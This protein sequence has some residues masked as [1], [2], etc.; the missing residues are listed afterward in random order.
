[1]PK[2]VFDQSLPDFEYSDTNRFR[3]RLLG[4]P[5]QDV[6][7][8]GVMCIEFGILNDEA[9]RYYMQAMIAGSFE[10]GLP[11]LDPT[12]RYMTESW[13]VTRNEQY[14]RDLFT[15]SQL[16]A[17]SAYI[18]FYASFVEKEY[19]ECYVSFWLQFKRSRGV[20]CI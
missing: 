11:G 9:V 14:L 20:L 12:H 17:I 2:D 6:P 18:W 16:D 15:A 3:K 8:E 1:M 19:M 13:F 10:P 7:P 5:W 4:K